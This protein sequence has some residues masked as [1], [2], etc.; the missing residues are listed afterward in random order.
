MVLSLPV[1][2][3]AAVGL[4]V[5]ELLFGGTIASMAVYARR[6][7]HTAV[8]R[9]LLLM[10]V[11]ASGYT[12]AS[13]GHVFVNSPTIS[14][15]IHNGTYVFGAALTVAGTLMTIAL[16][17]RDGLQ[18]RW[19]GGLLC[20][21]VL[22]DLTAAVTDPWFGFIIREPIFLEGGSIVRT[23]E[24]TGTYFFIRNAILFSL[25]A[26]SLLI[27]LVDLSDSDGIYRQQLLRVAVGLAFVIAMFLAQTVLPNVPG[28]DLA[29]I[30]LFGGTLMILLAVRQVDF[31]HALPV[32]HKTILDS[33]TDAVIV[34]SP[35]DRVIDINKRGVKLLTIQ[36]SSIGATLASCLPAAVAG[37]APFVSTGS[38]EVQFERN[39][40][41]RVYSYQVSPI[42]SSK[43][44]L[45]R[46]ITLQDIT[47]QKEQEL[48]LRNAW[49]KAQSERDA[50][51]LITELLLSSVDRH[52]ISE[53]ACQL[54]VE[55]YEYE[56][57]WV[58]S[59]GAED[60]VASASIR[61]D[62]DTI[63]TGAIE[64]LATRVIESGESET[65]ASCDE[66]VIADVL[67]AQQITTVRATPITYEQVTTGVLCVA[68][69]DEPPGPT[70]RVTQ[71]IATALGFKRRVAD[72]HT[73]LFADYVEEV[74]VRINADHFLCDV[75][76][77]RSIPVEV[78]ETYQA[79]EDIVYLI[80][81]ESDVV[82]L[83]M[84]LRDHDHVANVAVAS[85]DPTLLATQV[86]ATTVASIFADFGGS[87]RVIQ[88]AAGSVE[89]TVEFPPRTDVRAALAAISER[90][91]TA[92]ITKRQTRAA[93]SKN[94]RLP[95]NS[96]TE[97]QE[98]ALRAAAFLGFFDRP[99]QATAED[100]AKTLNVSRSTVL[101][102][103]R[104]AEKKIFDELFTSNSIPHGGAGISNQGD[105][106]DTHAHKHTRTE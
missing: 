104:R 17:G 31:G 5:I 95:I 23:A 75:T 13:G 34:V 97:R 16:T 47:K 44:Q 70:R 79:G 68:S 56:A 29:S 6:S 18:R 12:F 15:I 84:L 81:P 73:A 54:L 49:Y 91:A 90:W 55:T 46:I 66:D 9:Y 20:A 99:Q 38:G 92:H 105:G 50:K 52:K 96:L 69:V 100:V 63:K 24:Y 11:A 93:S 64:P 102:H 4:S 94:R 60:A 37:A 86:Q 87:T 3:P 10:L 36:R 33:M 62:T 106:D 40:T 82:D 71:Q 53:T 101:Q 2:V 19:V 85:T 32:A 65:V 7:R 77:E 72:Q 76:A 39:Q 8:G 42:M 14:H 45:G 89:I 80:Q 61:S 103:I 41:T 22:I 27:L 57:A 1:V 30:G 48:E 43:T 58:L 51:S 98:N 88:G 83:K 78:V 74:T 35:D 59:T 67:R 21:F 26:L 28:L 25:A